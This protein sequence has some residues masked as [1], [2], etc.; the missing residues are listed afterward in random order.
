MIGDAGATG[1]PLIVGGVADLLTLQPAAWAV[2]AT[3]LAT[4]AIFA[5]LMPETLRKRPDQTSEV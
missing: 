3:G 1:G 2:A 5:F 4:S